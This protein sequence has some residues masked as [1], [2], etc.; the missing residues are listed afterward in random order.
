VLR[1]AGP[2]HTNAHA[3]LLAQQEGAHAAAGAQPWPQARAWG[4]ELHHESV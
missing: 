4:G 2:S 1:S 3:H